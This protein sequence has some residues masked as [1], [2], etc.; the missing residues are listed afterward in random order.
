MVLISVYLLL[1]LLRWVRFYV[2]FTLQLWQ[3]HVAEQMIMDDME[4]NPDKYKGKK[5]SELTDEVEFDEENSVQYTQD[6]YKE[7]LLPKMVV[8]STLFALTILLVKLSFNYIYFL[9]TPER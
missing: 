3:I 7:S 6:Y 5:L 9:Y 1:T 4:I 8:V 2:L